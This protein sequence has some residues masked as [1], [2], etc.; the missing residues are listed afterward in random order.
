MKKFLASLTALILGG[1]SIFTGASAHAA[2]KAILVD[3]RIEGA[4][5]VSLDTTLY[6]PARLPAPA[7]LL[8]HGFAGDKS[9]VAARILCTH[10]LCNFDF[11]RLSSFC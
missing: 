9:S 5:G 6:L 7:I 2:S 8:A 1:L 3:Q 11:H 4:G 10:S